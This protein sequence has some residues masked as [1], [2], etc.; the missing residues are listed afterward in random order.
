[1]SGIG[2]PKGSK[3]SE[4]VYRL[5]KVVEKLDKL[6]KL[7]VAGH[8]IKKELG[9][10]LGLLTEELPGIPEKAR[11][12]RF[13]K[14]TYGEVIEFWGKLHHPASDA[15]WFFEKCQGNGW[16]NNGKAIVDWQATMRAWW[17]AGV[18]PSQKKG[19]LVKTIG[20]KDL[21]T[22]SKRIDRTL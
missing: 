13:C 18:F 3:H 2:F 5:S 11:P 12:K 10:I 16:K 17:L 21:D 1:M 7:S 19:S 15:D 22:I 8:A 4:G 20:E 6:S 14:P 9:V